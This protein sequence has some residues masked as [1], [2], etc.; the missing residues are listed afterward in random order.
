MYGRGPRQCTFK[1]LG[2]TRSKNLNMQVV[3]P[4]VG[5]REKLIRAHQKNV[6]RYYILSVLAGLNSQLPLLCTFHCYDCAGNLQFFCAV[7]PFV[8]ERTSLVHCEDFGRRGT[9]L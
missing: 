2:R 9:Q 3:Q 7:I 6:L 8:W 5:I 1:T 4:G